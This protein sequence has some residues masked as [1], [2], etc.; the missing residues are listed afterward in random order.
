MQKYLWNI[1]LT[2]T[3]YLCCVSV[4]IAQEEDEKETIGTEKV[5]IVKAYTPTISDAFKIKTQ[6]K[7]EDS[8]ERPQKP[9][10]YE[11]NSVP[12]ASTFTPAKG[13]AA[14]VEK[15]KPIKL[16]DNYAT[17]GF[18][19]F[20]RALAE[21][22]S[23]FEISRTDA[24]GLY[25][26]HNSSQGGIDDVRLDDT[27]YD[28][29]ISVDYTSRQ[30][31]MSYSIDIGGSHQ[32]YNWYSLPEPTEL[33][34]EEI[35]MIDPQHS[36]IGATVGGEVMFEEAIFRKLTA[37]YRYFGDTFSSVEHRAIIKPTV[38]IPVVDEKI[39]TT[40]SADYVG[41]SFEETSMLP[42]TSQ[43]S[44]LNLGISPELVILRNNLTLNLG[45]T[46][47]FS[48]DTENSETKLYIVPNVTASYGL[49]G[50]NVIA[51]GGLTGDLRQNTYRDA[52]AQNP[53]VSPSLTLRPT[54]EQFDA[55]A[56]IK[57][58]L[59]NGL[60]YNIKGGFKAAFDQN[61]FL[62]APESENITTREGF[63]YGNSFGYVYDD[64]TTA[65]GTAEIS[66]DISKNFQ[67]GASG[68][69]NAYG[70]DEQE[71]AWNLPEI[72]GSVSL[73][74]QITEQWYLDSQ[75][76]FIG[77]RKDIRPRFRQNGL[78]FP[79]STVTLDSYVDVNA[80]VGYRFNERLSFFVRGNNLTG[81]YEK[82]QFY[83][84]QGVQVLGG[85]TYK[86]DF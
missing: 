79:A 68:T 1:L 4:A 73:N 54:N 47:Y 19:N 34:D 42:F 84:V 11:I 64:I 85:A 15:A 46:L 36:Y 35:R 41:G 59:F 72:E 57:G 45:A 65:Y 66:L 77:E 38:E 31:D 8:I 76:F 61:L 21:F 71:E 81:S 16:F 22:Y 83:P 10:Q 24:I 58:N 14:A 51:F 63:Q 18:G 75:V 26:H 53:F 17:L 29:E 74:Y 62:H 44:F 20:T 5:V 23:N 13:R 55:F 40:F 2:S 48:L 69:F 37:R 49:L 12:V 30:R 27:F 32:L 33:T 3:V 50:T 39:L 56:G 25:L 60:G 67:L 9:V 70:T 7:I 52:V 28:S 80:T 86:F 43:Y 78:T 6:P 82:W